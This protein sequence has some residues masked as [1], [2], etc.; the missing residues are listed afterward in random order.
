MKRFVTAALAAATLAV[1]LAPVQ[2]AAQDHRGYYRNDDDDDWDRDDQGYYRDDDRRDWR[3]DHDRRDWRR[4]R[5]H[6][7]GYHR[8]W[9]RNR[10]NGYTYRGVWFYGPPPIAYYDD[11]YYD[12][13]YRVW[14]RGDRLPSYYRSRYREVDWRD[15]GL[16]RPPRGYRYVEDDR[17]GYL[18]VGIATGIILGAFLSNGY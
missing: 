12:P 13:G 14:R 5:D 16:R 18:L 8:G 2:A 15:C 9:D 11:P 3:R 10:Y 1:P 6:D 17:G 4:E 7:R